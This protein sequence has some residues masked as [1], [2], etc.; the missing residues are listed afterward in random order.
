MPK[1]KRKAKHGKSQSKIESAPFNSD[2]ESNLDNESVISAATESKCGSDDLWGDPETEESGVYD[3]FEEKLQDA[4]DGTSQKSTKGRQTCLETIKKALSCRF[5]YDFLSERKMTVF[6]MLERCLKKGKDEEQAAAALLAAMI[7]IHFGAGTESEQL[8]LDLQPILMTLMNDPSVNPNTRAKC[9]T[10][11]GVCCFI[12][13]DGVETMSSVLDSLHIIFSASYLKG[14]G[15]V[16][17]H[18]PELTQLHSSALVSWSLLLTLCSTSFISKTLDLQLPRLPEILESPDV[19]L[20]IAAG[21]SVAIL[22]ELAREYDDNFVGD[23]IDDL[24]TKLQLLATD[25]QKFRAKKD[26]RQQRSSFRDILRYVETREAP[27]MRIKFGREILN[28]NTWCR[29]R[30]YDSLCQILGSGM[31]LHLTENELL[32]DIFELGTPM[33]THTLLTTKTNKLE[34]H[35]ANIASCKARTKSRNRLRDKRSD[36]IG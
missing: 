13:G 2:D 16:P 34:R 11:L 5:E 28:I 25:S 35:I 3:D 22:Y 18:T 36:I 15:V 17:N 1:G 4:I 8:Y 6:D 30:Q 21:E 20:R 14:N 33:A 29:K 19:D 31:N 7:C 24:C 9:A 27:D 10:A 12:S 32:R 26:R 23:D